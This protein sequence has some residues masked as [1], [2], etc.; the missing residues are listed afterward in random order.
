MAVYPCAIGAHRYGG[1]QRSAYITD[2]SNSRP[3]TWKLRLC[4]RHYDRIE[5]DCRLEMTEIK[6][7]EDSQAS[8][9]CQA[10]GCERARSL[11]LFTKL[12]PGGED[13]T[14]W[15]ADLCEEHGPELLALLHYGE[16][17]KL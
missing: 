15:A 12:Y 11:I 14:Q 16:A 5:E 4:Q 17:T 13:Y 2:C 1:A 6:D 8:M 3:V 10:E 9:F 7:D